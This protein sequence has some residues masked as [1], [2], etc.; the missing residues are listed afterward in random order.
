MVPQ[1]WPFLKKTLCQF[2][3]DIIK[4]SPLQKVSEKKDCFYAKLWTEKG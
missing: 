4:I 1:N 3:I 2:Q